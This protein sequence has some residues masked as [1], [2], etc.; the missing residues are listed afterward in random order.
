MDHDR[1]DDLTRTL[2]TGMSRRQALKL[3]GSSLLAGL[4]PRQ[5]LAGGG[6]SA[7]AKFCAQVFGANTPA[8]GKC[9]SD[10]AKGK[11]LCYRCGPAAPATHP[12][13]C[14]QVCCSAGQGCCNGT[15]TN[16]NTTSNCGS[17]GH[18]CTAPTNG[19]ATCANGTCGFTCNTGFKECNGT[20]IPSGN[21]CNDAECNGGQT[22]QNGTCACPTGTKPCNG[23][24]IPNDQ[25]CNGC[26]P[27]QTCQ[28]GTCV[29]V[30]S[31]TFVCPP[32]DLAGRS[33]E[34]SST[35]ATELFCRYQT[36][37]NDFFCK[38]FLSTGLLKQDHDQGRCP[39]VAIPECHIP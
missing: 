32:V 8:A 19:T 38:Y 24:C 34:S 15:C 16:L 9:T 11:G 25:C 14:G 31:C 18:T 1:F 37:P 5:V 2:A 23:S 3:L 21:C 12:P 4:L 13:L 36:V 39:P 30:P 35:T 27:G 29:G 10:A 20:C 28:N 33:L 6:N 26:P 7:C 22:C 17:C